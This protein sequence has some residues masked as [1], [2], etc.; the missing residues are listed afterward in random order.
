MPAASADTAVLR[1]ASDPFQ[2]DGG[3]RLLTGN[4]G[5]AVIKVSAVKPANRI[6]EAPAGHWAL[7]GVRHESTRWK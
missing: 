2:A 7:A 3:L 1:P 5:R 6:V 4:L